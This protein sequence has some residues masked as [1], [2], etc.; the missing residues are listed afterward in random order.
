MSRTRRARRARR[1]SCT[2]SMRVVG[3]EREELVV[4]AHLA[5]LARR[6]TS[7]RAS[8][9]RCSTSYGPDDVERGDAVEHEAGDVHGWLLEGRH[10]HATGRKRSRYSVGSRRRG[11]RRRGACVSAVPKPGG[12]GDLVDAA[13]PSSRAAGAPPRRAPARR[14]RR[15]CTR[16]RRG[17]RA[18]S[19][20]GS[21]RPAPRAA[22][23]C[24]PR[25]DARRSTLCSSR[26]GSRSAVCAPSCA[27][28]CAWPPGPLHEHHELARDMQRDVA[29][30]VVGDER[31]REVHARGDARPTS[32]RCRR[33]RRSD[34]ARR[35]IAGIAACARS[36]HARQC[37]VARLPS[38]SPRPR[39]GTRPC[40]PR[41]P[42]GCDAASVATARTSRGR[43]AAATRALRRRRRPACR[44]ARARRAATGRRRSP[45]PA[46]S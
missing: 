5:R 35:S 28:N 40:T 4:G 46:T 23:R 22:R 11:G 39:A 24:G 21:S 10:W 9:R 6:R 26:S 17:T 3:D 38:S 45:G 12:A 33:A 19:G 16:P 36:S 1:R 29:A 18:R 42:A 20:A 44:S 30:E 15:A 13:A 37:V 2:S 25:R 27:L 43:R 31:E 7:R 14:T 8:G 32:T 41:R 34:P